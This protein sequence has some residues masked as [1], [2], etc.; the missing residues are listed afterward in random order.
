MIIGLC[1]VYLGDPGTFSRGVRPGLRPDGLPRAWVYHPRRFGFITGGGYSMVKSQP[2]SAGKAQVIPMVAWRKASRCANG[3]C[4]E[5]S[6]H[7]GFV[8]LRDS[9]E[10]SVV[11]RCTAESWRAFTDAIKA[12][13]LDDSG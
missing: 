6:E 9:S 2:E 10:T 12:G 7:D 11:L 4:L 1:Q 5:V 8:M 13:E 3:E